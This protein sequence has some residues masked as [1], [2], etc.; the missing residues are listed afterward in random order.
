MQN[1]L[2]VLRGAHCRRSQRVIAWLEEQGIPF[3]LHEMTSPE[4]QALAERYDVRASPGLVKNGRVINPFD[5]LRECKLDEAAA[6]ALL[7]A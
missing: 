2:V 6:H 4:G 5:F 7:E 1:E 3:T